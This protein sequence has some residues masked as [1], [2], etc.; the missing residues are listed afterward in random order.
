MAYNSYKWMHKNQPNPPPTVMPKTCRG[1][2]N[3]DT[4]ANTYN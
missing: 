1:K 3:D 2:G 4:N